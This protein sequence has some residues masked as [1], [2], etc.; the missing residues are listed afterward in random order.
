MH[1][2]SERR[3]ARNEALFRKTNEAIARGQWPDDPQKP[4]RFRCECSRMGC[5]Q[6]VEIALVDYERV[7]S[8]P[9]R[10]VLAPGH[11]T[12][13]IETVIH[14]GERH[15]VVEKQ[16]AAGDTAAAADPRR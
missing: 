15:V 1:E 6:A 12:P 13:Q 7:R 10:F 8:F 16:E 11:E 3:L 5:D 4:V 9:R 14:R 2:E